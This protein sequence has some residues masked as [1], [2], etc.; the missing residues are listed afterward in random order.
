[1]APARIGCCIPFCR[2]T[3]KNPGADGI[4]ATEWICGPH[5]IAVPKERRRVYG[6]LKRAWRRFHFE[7]DGIRSARIWLRLKRQAIEAAVGIR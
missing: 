5:W 7:A 3:R 6:R 2:R 1:M 4:Y